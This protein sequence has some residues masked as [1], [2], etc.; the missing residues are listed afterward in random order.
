MRSI[1]YAL[2][3][4]EDNRIIEFTFDTYADDTYTLVDSAPNHYWGD[5]LF[6]DGEYIY[7]PLPQPEPPEP[8]ETTDDVLNALLG[9]EQTDGGETNE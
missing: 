9:I 2:K 5:C 8:V 7:D 6:I 1:K 3:T 4:D